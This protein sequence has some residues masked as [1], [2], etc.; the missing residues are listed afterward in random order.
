MERTLVACKSLRNTLRFTRDKCPFISQ[1]KVVVVVDCGLTSH[2]AIFQ[3]YS[4]GANDKKGTSI[5]KW[6]QHSSLPLVKPAFAIDFL[7]L[8]VVVEIS[9]FIYKVLQ[10]IQNRKG[11]T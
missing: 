2:S 4:D 7:N 3:L 11:K 5:L 6:D 9:H 10:K 8:L 1:C